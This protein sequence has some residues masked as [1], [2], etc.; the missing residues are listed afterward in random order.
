MAIRFRHEAAAGLIGAYAAGEAESRRRAEKYSLAMLMEQLRYNQRLGVL[1]ARQGALGA[2]AGAVPRPLGQWNDPLALGGGQD[3]SQV[4]L[5]AARRARD[6]KARLGVPIPSQWQPTY[7]SP[8]EI[9]QQQKQAEQ[10]QK[11]AH[12]EQVR[13]GEWER[14]GAWRQ[15]EWKREDAWRKQ[16]LEQKE[17]AA[18]TT[19]EGRVRAEGRAFSRRQLEEGPYSDEQRRAA[20]KILTEMEL[21]RSDKKLSPEEQAAAV[22][23]KQA[24][25]DKI[26][27]NPTGVP[28]K[29]AL[30][31]AR[32]N[33]LLFD[34]DRK[35]FV[36]R[37]EAG[38]NAFV[39]PTDPDG[40][41]D[42]G[43][44][45]TPDPAAEKEQKKKDDAV[46]KKYNEYRKEAAK[47]DYEGPLK[48]KDDDELFILAQKDI[49]HE[50]R[51]RA[52]LG[53]IRQN[54]P[55]GAAPPVTRPGP[56]DLISPEPGPNDLFTPMPNAPPT[57]PSG[58]VVPLPNAKPRRAEDPSL[59]APMPNAK[60]V[61]Q[62]ERQNLTR[63]LTGATG[64][65]LPT[66]FPAGS[67]WVGD[68]GI[69]LPDGRII[70][71]KRK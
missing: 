43:H 35:D 18:A 21:A 5:N 37:D 20:N 67:Q 28:N 25:F 65:P 44:A 39:V 55:G 14:K 63:P 49:A 32:Q 23:I 17:G 70:R 51:R 8:W 46:I 47:P 36:R 1:G 60:P 24:E 58:L 62:A 68:E 16:Q 64:R 40:N 45:Q 56:N 30:D 15:E 4:E 66:G 57:A 29:T 69:R 3:L 38:P 31:R 52:E 34:P 19:A 26:L 13:Q 2:R 61:T 59:I 12:E 11:W 27:A 53:A 6:R 33:M 42:W 9:E 48:G 7:T 71:R 54:K 22:A 41:P 50:E 10:Q